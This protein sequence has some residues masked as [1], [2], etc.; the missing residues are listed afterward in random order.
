MRLLF[1]RRKKLT[2]AQIRRKVCEHPWEG[3]GRSDVPLPIRSARQSAPCGGILELACASVLCLPVSTRL[4][5]GQIPSDSEVEHTIR[6]HLSEQ[7]VADRSFILVETAGG[8]HSPTLSGSSQLDAYRPLRL[9]TILI[10]S[11]HLGGISSTIS[12]YESLLIRGYDVDAVLCLREDYY[13]NFEYFQSYFGER[14]IPTAFPLPPPPR[15]TSPHYDRAQLFNYFHGLDG[16]DPGSPLADSGL[17]RVIT[18]LASRHNERLAD[19]DTAG[20]RTLDCV[21]WPFVQHTHIKS[22]KDVM[23]IDSANGD[24]FGVLSPSPAS[25][26]SP[27][28]EPVLDGSAS[29]WSQGLG[30]AHVAL[31]LAAANAAGRYGHVMFPTATHEPALRLAERLVND[32]GQGW[33]SRC[34]YSDDGSTAMEVALK[35]AFRLHNVRSGRE[36]RRP[37]GVLGLK[38]S[39]HGDTIGAMDASPPNVYN[40]K[41]DWYSGRGLWLDPPVVIL[42]EGKPVIRFDGEDWAGRAEDT[43]QSSLAEVYDVEKRL[44]SDALVEKYTQHITSFLNNAPVELGALVLEPILMGAGGMLFVDPLF[45]SLLVRLARSHSRL[46]VIYDEVFSGMG[47]LGH[48]SAGPSLLDVEPDIAAYAKV[49]TGGLVPLSV[50]LANEEVFNAFKGETKAEAL[51]HGHS[52]TAHPV[53]CAVANKALDLLEGMGVREGRKTSW[54]EGFV[55]RMS[56]HERVEGAMALGTVLALYLRDAEGQGA[57]SHI[58]LVWTR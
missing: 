24:D 33:A 13:R 57:L 53:G 41:V 26:S 3:A 39:Y 27:L 30:H 15:H 9:P 35:M 18:S 36:D 12:A 4:S 1:S 25:P 17:S 11:H 54:D 51:L 21:W 20:E 56:S 45:Q 42:K 10:G 14:Q 32:V 52:Y 34:F 6:R 19:L 50:T 5:S 2:A 46:P 38:G 55:A 44:Q 22:A 58:S 29:W 7:A 49:L 8:V 43:S 28:L 37:L 47:R 16:H 23:V 31:T 40:A 48:F